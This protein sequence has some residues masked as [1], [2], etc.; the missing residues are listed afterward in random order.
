[1]LRLALAGGLLIVGLAVGLAAV[2]VHAL[3]WGLP[4]AVATTALTA[5]AAPGGWWARLPFALGWAAMV[6]VLSVP[7][8][9]GGFLI[10]GDLNGYVLLGL[11]VSVLVA[12]FVTLPLPRNNASSDA[13]TS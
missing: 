9:D 11:G 3:W 13:A 4:L 6:G 8:A 2:A 1:M 5:Y 10:A 7:H 12:S